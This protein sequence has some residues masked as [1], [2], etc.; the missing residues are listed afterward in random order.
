M[1]KLLIGHI[2]VRSIGTNDV[3]REKI[4]ES[5]IRENIDICAVTETWYR[6]NDRDLKNEFKLIQTEGSQR[7]QGV[8]ILIRKNICCDI[9][10]IYPEFVNR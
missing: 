9:T 4:I 7:G 3:K 2:N 5:L 10:S 6:F 8:A 1:N